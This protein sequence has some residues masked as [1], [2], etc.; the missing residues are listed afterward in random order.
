M[1]A[2]VADARMPRQTPPTNS[3]S[4]AAGHC[5][6]IDPMRVSEKLAHSG[7]RG[8]ASP[9]LACHARRRPPVRAA[10]SPKTERQST[11]CEFR[12]NLPTDMPG[13]PRSLGL[14]ILLY[15]AAVGYALFVWAPELLVRYERLAERHP[16]LANVYA[17]AVI[18]GGA[19]LAIASVVLFV[20]LSRNTRIKR[21][22]H[23]RRKADPRKLSAKQ[24]LA[25]LSDN[26]ASSQEL[27]EDE[28]VAAELREAL[29]A[30]LTALQQKQAA[31]RLEIV[32]FGTVSSGK[33]SLLNALAGRDAF[34]SHV[35][36]GT[37]AARCEIPWGRLDSVVLVDT[38]GLAEVRGEKR[39]ALAA[40]AAKNADLVLLVVDGPLKAYEVE[41]AERL[42]AMEKRLIVCLNKEDWYDR[43]QE[44]ELVA[45]IAEQLPRIDKA[46][47]V[48]VRAAITARPRVQVLADGREETTFVEEPPDVQPLARRMLEVVRR[49]GRDLIAANLLLQSRGLVDEAKQQVRKHLDERADQIINRYMWAAGGAAGVNPFPL[50][51][52]AGS[53]A[54]TLKMVL[55]LARVYRQP[56]DADMAVKMLAQLSKNL[57]AMVGATAAAPVAASLIASMMKTVPGVGTLAGGLVQGL[58]QALVTRWIGN[59]FVRYLQNEMQPPPGGLAE[60]ARH[61]WQ[62]LT[63]PESLRR[64]IALGRE[65]LRSAAKEDKEESEKS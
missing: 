53:S 18:G 27:A 61:E 36:G 1:W 26:L 42:I 51:D 4:D 12:R 46:D 58:V 22:H 38:P 17:A 20:R 65:Q 35:V 40:D 55:D 29:K 50:L 34:A 24:R 30:Q 14:L 9:T 63:R 48:P 47:V 8:R 32:A 45:Q 31:Q 23:E 6:P 56:L 19:L 21:E 13:R 10:T 37:T 44:Q 52:I 16:Q 3:R 15:A 57:L 62:Q 39:A 54:I 11:K 5:T 43:R 7:T 64:L 33:S 41:L 28:T 25:E 2:S 60:V 49:D 59:V